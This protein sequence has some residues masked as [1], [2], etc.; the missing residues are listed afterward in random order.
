MAQYTI[1]AGG[2][3]TAASST[4]VSTGSQPYVMMVTPDSGPVAAFTDVPATTG[5]ASTF[6]S[7]STDADEAITTQTWN[8][9]D[10]S[11]TATGASVSHTY[12][13]PGI[14]TVTLTVSDAAGCGLGFP[15]FAGQAGPFTGIESA[16]SPDASAQTSQTVTIPAVAASARSPPS[17]ARSR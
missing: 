14:Y 7:T 17:P 2:M 13:S 9:G 1:G 5:S 15:L 10:G 16:C 8:F 12:A 11:A 6:T 3:L 4:P